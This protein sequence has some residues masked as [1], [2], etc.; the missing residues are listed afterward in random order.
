[1][2]GCGDGSA[3]VLSA[4][5][6]PVEIPTAPAVRILVVD[7][8][9]E[10]RKV[11]IF[12]LRSVASDSIV[13]AEADDVT[14]TMEFLEADGADAV[15]V[16]ILSPG[17]VELIATVRRHYPQLAILVCSF[18]GDPETRTRA[19]DAGADSYLVKPMGGRDLYGAILAL[20][21]RSAPPPDDS[22][23]PPDDS[24]SDVGLVPYRD[25]QRDGEH[26]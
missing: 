11:I 8:R 16:E 25:V 21:E 3:A 26:R 23:P 10:R 14:K 6:L 12:T 19:L 9:P 18:Q 5:S 2:P 1:V 24:P 15:V 17:A 7:D 22:P 4:A 13:V 20:H